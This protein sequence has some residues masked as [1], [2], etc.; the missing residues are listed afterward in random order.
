MLCAV[1]EIV[2]LIGKAEAEQVLHANEH[3]G[4]DKVKAVLESIFIRLM[5][6]SKDTISELIFK[7]KQRLNREKEVT[8]K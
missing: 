5:S 8:Q 7:I 4:Q 1:P 2:E 6:S 3:V